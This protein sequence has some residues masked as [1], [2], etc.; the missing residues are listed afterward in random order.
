MRLSTLLFASCLLAFGSLAAAQ[1]G[2]HTTSIKIPNYIGLKIVNGAGDIRTNA[3]VEF[4]YEDDGTDL[5]TYMNA[6]EAGGGTLPP[7]EVIE[8]EDIQVAT[9][10]G[11]EWRIYTR[12]LNPVGF[13]ADSGFRLNDVRVNPG[14]VSG[15]TRSARINAMLGGW[16]LRTNYRYIVRGRGATQGWDSLGFNGHDYVIRVQ[17]DE[18]PGEHQ[19]SVEYLLFFP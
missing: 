11:G 14:S 16:D 1:R 5:V 19:V 12:S 7:T 3:S 8:F 6:I 17:G 4:N 13:A 9:R 15:L 18:Q 10:G 2:D